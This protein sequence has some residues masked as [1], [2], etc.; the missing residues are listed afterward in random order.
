M[1]VWSTYA[2]VAGAK[3]GYVLVPE[4]QQAYDL[5]TTQV[6][7]DSG[8]KLIAVFKADWAAG[9]EVGNGKAL[10]LTPVSGQGVT[11]YHLVTLSPVLENNWVRVC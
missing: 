1:Q 11:D 7:Y 4:L 6:G 5:A 10:T 2:T 8:D 3:Y 9:T